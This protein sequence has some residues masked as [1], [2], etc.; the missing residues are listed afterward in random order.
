MSSEVQYWD[1]L[2]IWQYSRIVISIYYTTQQC[3]SAWIFSRNCF[4]MIYTDDIVIYN[5]YMILRNK[6]LLVQA[7]LFKNP[8][9]IIYNGYLLL[10]QC[11]FFKREWVATNSRWGVLLLP[12]PFFSWRENR[13]SQ[14]QGGWEIWS[15]F[16][17][18][19]G[20]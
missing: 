20:I 1:C 19:A 11:L 6:R 5:L 4:D 7:E 15:P 16:P 12:E 9:C 10:S 18:N 14:I 13:M 3:K 2:M 17:L 8:L